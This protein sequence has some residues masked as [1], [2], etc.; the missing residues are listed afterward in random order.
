MS[1]PS[2]IQLFDLQFQ[3]NDHTVAAFLLESDEGPVLIETGPHSTFPQLETCIREA[4]YATSDIRHVLLTHIHLDHAGAAW[5]F[6]QRG[7]KIYVHPLGAP[8][9]QRPE[10]LY[11]SAKLIYQD[12]MEELW[13][14]LRPIDEA[15]L[16]TA[17]H[18]EKIPIGNLEFMAW[19]TPGHAVHHIAWQNG[20]ELFTGDVAGICING[21]MVSAPCPPPDINIEDWKA[22]IALI[23]SLPVERL[24]LT[25]FG[26][27]NAI[28]LHLDE[29]E[30]RLDKWSKWMW[31]PFSEGIS[32]EE[33]TPQFQ[34]FAAMELIEAGIDEFDMNRYESSNPA[35]MS[36]AGLMR[37]WKKKTAV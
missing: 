8:H 37:Y 1:L 4:G 22:S 25:H 13:G 33:I 12:K 23:R 36:V 24:W 30:Y 15:Q 5:E 17:A 7:A 9:M 20:S 28:Q 14:D 21:G 6:A 3:G 18:Q 32:I 29:L 16:Q 2:H 35:W 10:K 27:V 26:P 34:E 31:K 19:H 11:H